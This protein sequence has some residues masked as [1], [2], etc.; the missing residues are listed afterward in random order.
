MTK[1][2]STPLQGSKS[3]WLPSA[4]ANGFI[5]YSTSTLPLCLDAN[6]PKLNFFKNPLYNEKNYVN[7][8]HS[9][10]LLNSNTKSIKK[11]DKKNQNHQNHHS[12]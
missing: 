2:P 9:D 1:N 6:T 12:N 4:K 11:M 3:P 5:D 8:S 10:Q 7:L